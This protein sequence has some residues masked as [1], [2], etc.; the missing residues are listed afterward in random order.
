MIPGPLA[1]AN[2]LLATTAP[3][4]KMKE[5]LT[6]QS[7]LSNGVGDMAIKDTNRVN[8]RNLDVVAEYTK[9]KRKNAAN[10]V[11]IGT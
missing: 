2:L 5:S 10:F 8:S 4:A 7:D 6:P 1:D 3:K 9:V 11:V